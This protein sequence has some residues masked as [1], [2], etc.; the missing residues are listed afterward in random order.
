VSGVAPANVVVLGAGMAGQNA[1]WIA[2]GMEAQVTL[3]DTN[4]DKL[5]YVD[6]IHKGRIQTLVSNRRTIEGLTAQA[7]MVIGSVLVTGAKAPKLVTAE[8]V[9]NM[10]PGSVLIDIAIDQGGCFE[11]SHV[12]TH[13]EPTYVVDDVIHYCVGNM[14]GAVPHTSTYALTNVTLPYVLELANHGTEAALRADDALRK[15]VN[16]WNGELVNEPVAAAHDLPV[17]HLPF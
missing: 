10:K 14:P 17:A 2:Q 8:M 3:L 11:T 5:R 6:A 13:S 4:V 7:D 12:T 1:A 15:G 16:V 9:R